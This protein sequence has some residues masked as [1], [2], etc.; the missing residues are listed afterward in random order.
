MYKSLLWSRL[1]DEPERASDQRSENLTFDSRYGRSG[2][3]HQGSL[4][5]GNGCTRRQV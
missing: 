1:R 4:P 3:W 2:I 5:D